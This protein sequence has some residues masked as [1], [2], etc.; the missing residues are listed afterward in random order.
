YSARCRGGGTLSPPVLHSE[1]RVAAELGPR[2]W[3]VSSLDAR[4]CR[5][6]EG[7]NPVRT[8]RLNTRGPR[9]RG[10]DQLE[11]SSHTPENCRHAVEP[12]AG[13]GSSAI[14]RSPS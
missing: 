8:L 12:R 7:G 13:L 3:R 1:I 9:L 5:F 6:R 11:C 14:A 4:S 2:F 10:G